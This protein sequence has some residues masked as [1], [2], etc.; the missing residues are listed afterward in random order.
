MSG[1]VHVAYVGLGSNLDDPP[2]RVREA[3]DRLRA[4]PGVLCVLES[5]LYQTAPVGVTGQPPFVNAC[6]RVETTL[7]PDDLLAA[8][9]E[10]ERAMGRVRAERWGPRVIDLD[11]L[12]YDDLVL[13]REGLAVPHPE[14]QRRAF[15][16]VPLAEIAPDA[17]HPV[18]GKTVAEMLAALGPAEGVRRL[19]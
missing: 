7:A 15:V 5:S 17:R 11:L 8:L 19:S 4:T 18:L 6:A 9:L 1:E 16:L 14:M 10:I 3:L 2:A 12:L 13:D